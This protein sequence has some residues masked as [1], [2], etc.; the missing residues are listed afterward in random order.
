IAATGLNSIAET[1]GKSVKLAEQLPARLQEK[2]AGLKQSLAEAPAASSRAAAPD[3]A[4]AAE[5]ARLET[6]ADHVRQAAA[7]LARLETA[8]QKNLAAARAELDAKA[9]Q[10][11]SQLDAKI[12]LLA[13]LAEKLSVPAR[14]APMEMTAPFL[15]PSPKIETPPEEPG[16]VVSAPGEKPAAIT[17]LAEEPKMPRK[18]APKKPK[19]EE[20]EPSLGLAGAENPAPPPAPESSEPPA[21]HESAPLPDESSQMSPEDGAPVS[22]VSADGATRLLVT[23][24]ICIGN[25]LFILGEGPGLSWDKGMPLNF[26]SIGKWRWETADA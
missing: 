13:A 1:L 16:P 23:A 21:V 26:V 19:P 24:Y 2:I 11:L 6:T 20:S 12:S 5:N 10:V 18:R 22:A 7:E 3:P 8:A 15:T 17:E 25:R 4:F 14:P 9:E